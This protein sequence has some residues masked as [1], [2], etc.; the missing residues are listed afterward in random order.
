MKK[1]INDFK[2]IS[3]VAVEA[4][5]WL[6]VISLA[7]F[8]NL[9]P[10]AFI[11]NKPVLLAVMLFA[12]SVIIL[13]GATPSIISPKKKA[14][15]RLGALIFALLPF[16]LMAIGAGN[17]VIFYY[18][19]VAFSVSLA[20]L[21]IVMPKAYVVMLVA[22]SVF[23]LSEVFAGIY[24]GPDA[25]LKFPVE[26]SRKFSL[27][28]VV[29]FI[30]YLYRK[31]KSLRNELRAL[32]ER[33]RIFEEKKSE[34]VANLSHELRTPLTSIKN[35][36]LLLEKKMNKEILVPDVPEKEIL[37]VITSNVDRQARLIDRLLNLSKIES[38]SP[39]VPEK[40]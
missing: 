17:I 9:S 21:I 5:F 29:M 37:D 22:V 8:M 4:I 32:N 26:I 39:V 19:P 16:L 20:Y 12:F 11:V 10:K 3:I 38:G 30:Y 33:I 18:L 35:S 2:R 40:E 1:D 34:L 14:V 6:A 15:F 28:L 13:V 36:V 7:I 31:E 25:K 27:I 23:F 24:I